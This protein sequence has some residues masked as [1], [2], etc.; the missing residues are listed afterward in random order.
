[1]MVLVHGN[2]VRAIQAGERAVVI[3]LVMGATGLDLIAICAIVSGVALIE[4]RRSWCTA[5][6]GGEAEDAG[7]RIG[8]VEDAVG[9]AESFD[10][11]D[12][13]GRNASQVEDCLLY[14]SRCV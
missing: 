2:V 9:T 4:D 7:R 1:M 3:E 11:S 12:S 10:R 6:R 8:A 13:R 14:T 5:T